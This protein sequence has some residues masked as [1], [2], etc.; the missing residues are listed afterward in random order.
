MT[1]LSDRPNRA[2]LVVDV[3]VGVVDGAHAVQAVV[4]N[5]AAV[6]E[7][8]R[9]ANVPVINSFARLAFPAT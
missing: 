6:M 8:A 7:K 5:I 2:L 9:D 4:A 1:A 3:Q